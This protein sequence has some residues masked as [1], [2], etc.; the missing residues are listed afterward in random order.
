MASLYREGRLQDG[1]VLRGLR[2]SG[3]SVEGAA[4]A[5]AACHRRSGLGSAEGRLVVPPITGSWLERARSTNV[6]GA[7]DQPPQR[8]MRQPYDAAAFARAVREGVDPSGRVLSSLMPRYDLS[9]LQ[10]RQLNDYLKSLS[11]SVSPGVSEDTLHFATIVTPD[12][13]PTAR[14]AMLVVMRKFF[15]D[16]NA[17]IRGGARRM[18]SSRQIEYRVTRRWQLHE[19]RLTGPPSSWKAQ[20]HQW[21]HDE[22]VFAVV[23]GIGGTTWAPIHDFC[24]EAGLPCLFPNT[25]NPKINEQD[26]YPLYFSRGLVLEADLIAGQLRAGSGKVVQLVRA[27]DGGEA[28]AARL[29]SDMAAGGRNPLQ[30]TLVSGSPQEL[31]QAL[32][33][34]RADDTLVLWLSATELAALPQRPPPAAAIYVSGLLGGLDQMPL[35]AAWRSVVQVAYTV[36]PPSQRGP[37]MNFPLQWFRISGIPVKAERVQTDTYIACGILAEALAEMLDS[38]YRDYLVERIETMLSHR[39]VTGY[40]PRLSLSQGE[41]FASKGGFLARYDASGDALQPVSEWTIPDLAR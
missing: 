17:F 36:D 11:G 31:E 7:A 24:E 34:A 26:F 35:P 33:K 22:P 41:R 13:D 19:W 6:P 18:V 23:S 39:L 20:L 14:D 25:I 15:E 9:D 40:Y 4:A 10:L 2:D 12:A 5:C 8:V 30:V 29:R 21:L 32:R 16:K 3:Q 28:G 37:R 38:F 1:R 27:G